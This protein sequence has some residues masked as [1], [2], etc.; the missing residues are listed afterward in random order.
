MVMPRCSVEKCRSCVRLLRAS[1]RRRA[2]SRMVSSGSMM[3]SLRARPSRP[4]ETRVQVVVFESAG[5]AELME[6]QRQRQTLLG[7]GL[8]EMRLHDLE[9]PRAHGLLRGLAAPGAYFQDGVHET[10]IVH[11]A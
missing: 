8:R 3:I 7:E 9:Q 1:Y 4:F 5:F 10:G 11:G 2:S 6:L